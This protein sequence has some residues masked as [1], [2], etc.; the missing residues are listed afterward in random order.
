M[1]KRRN[2]WSETRKWV[3]PAQ[4]QVLSRQQRPAGNASGASMARSWGPTVWTISKISPSLNRCP[5]STLR[6]RSTQNPVGRRGEPAKS[7]PRMHALLVLGR[8]SKRRDGMSLPVCMVAR[9][10]PHRRY[11][12]MGTG[13][14][15]ALRAHAFTPLSRAARG[16]GRGHSPGKRGQMVWP[17]AL[18]ASE[19]EHM[20][21]VTRD[22]CRCHSLSPAARARQ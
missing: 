20:P 6:P 21:L 10:S 14:R 4:I 1:P 16:R 17:M 18:R 15:Q 9:S 8:V 2:S 19:T 22:P 5:T 11:P 13:G 3:V 12:N 7:R